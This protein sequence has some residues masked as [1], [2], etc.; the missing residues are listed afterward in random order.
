MSETGPMWLTREEDV[1]SHLYFAAAEIGSATMEFG[2]FQV[3]GSLSFPNP[4]QGTFS[5]FTHGEVDLSQSPIKQGD[6]V[7]FSYSQGDATY[8]F[9][10]N[11]EDISD[12]AAR[13]RW[14]IKFPNAVERDQRR[15]VR[16]HRV[17]G[18]QGFQFSATMPGRGR[19][20]VALYDVA[21]AGISFVF[22]SRE[23]IKV[24]DSFSGTVEVP[25]TDPVKVSV[26]VR[27]VRPVPGDPKN[28]LAGCR[29]SEIAPMALESLSQ[30]LAK[31]G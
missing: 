13:R 26:E 2:S 25:G 27:N 20:Q 14:R 19:Q 3:P 21:A 7:R 29:F 6:V 5:F 11:V 30:A 17:M 4:E 12:Q 9:L 16:R 23:K 15:L 8:T 1:V 10:S 28:R 31:L 18:R 24:G 22:P